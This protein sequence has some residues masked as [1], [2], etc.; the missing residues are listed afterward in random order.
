MTHLFKSCFIVYLSL[1]LPN[2]R[3]AKVLTSL[4]LKMLYLQKTVVVKKYR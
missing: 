3:P 2:L 4:N 1:F